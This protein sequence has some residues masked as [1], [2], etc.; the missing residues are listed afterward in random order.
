MTDTSFVAIGWVG[1]AAAIIAYAASI[2]LRT[3][4]AREAHSRRFIGRSR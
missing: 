1:T 2:G 4:R 3:R